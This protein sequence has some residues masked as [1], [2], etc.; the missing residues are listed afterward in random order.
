VSEHF[1]LADF[2]THDQQTVW[3]KYL[4]LNESLVD[5]LELVIQELRARGTT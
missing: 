3:P 2:L 5:K 4:V 1:R